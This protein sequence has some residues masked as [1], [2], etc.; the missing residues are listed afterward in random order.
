M[1]ELGKEGSEAREVTYA[2]KKL[3]SHEKDIGHVS[4]ENLSQIPAALI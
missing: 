4:Y 3:N 2:E 1:R